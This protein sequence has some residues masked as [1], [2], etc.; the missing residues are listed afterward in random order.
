V[1]LPIEPK[2]TS[3]V[4]VNAGGLLHLVDWGLDHHPYYFEL[5]PSL[6]VVT[7]SPV[8][9]MAGD[10]PC[11]LATDGALTLIVAR[12]PRTEDPA[13]EYST[14]FAATFDAA[15]GKPIASRTLDLPGETS[16][17]ALL[18]DNA[19]V[20]GGDAY[21]LQRVDAGLRVLRLTANLIQRAERVLTTRTDMVVTSVT[22]RVERDHLVADV[23]PESFEIPFDLSSASPVPHRVR[24]IGPVNGCWCDSETAVSMGPVRALLCRRPDADSIAHLVAWDRDEP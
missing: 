19:A 9:G 20:A 13:I 17:S 4:M 8:V 16:R 2:N 1:A 10:R 23:P 15:T 21:V 24:S 22:L 12:R 5:A 11:A 14:I 6:E 18:R 3:P 7:K